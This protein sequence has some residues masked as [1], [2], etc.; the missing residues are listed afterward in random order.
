MQYA[1][2]FI[3]L[4]RY[5]TDKSRADRLDG[6]YAIFD[7]E[8]GDL[9]T[10]FAGAG[11]KSEG[12]LI[13]AK[14]LLMTDTVKKGRNRGREYTRTRWPVRVAYETLDEDIVE[15]E[16]IEEVPFAGNKPAGEDLLALVK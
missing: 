1:K 10:A 7:D 11:S 3:S 12:A 16:A 6:V 4:F 14:D 15:I 5:A 13:A 2:S 9:L 8:N